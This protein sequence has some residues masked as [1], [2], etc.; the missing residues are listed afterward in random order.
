MCIPVLGDFSGTR[1]IYN[2]NLVGFLTKEIRKFKLFFGLG[3]RAIFARAIFGNKIEP[4]PAHK[5][6]PKKV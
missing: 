6:N 2:P 3:S 1:W 5:P 4:P